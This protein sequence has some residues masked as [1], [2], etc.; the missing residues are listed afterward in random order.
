MREARNG[1]LGTYLCQVER[2]EKEDIK[3]S[4][5]EIEKWIVKSFQIKIYDGL[6][7]IKNGNIDI[8]IG[9]TAAAIRRA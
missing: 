2:K 3:N 6:E 5:Y 8:A 9:S 7:I 4:L 1:G